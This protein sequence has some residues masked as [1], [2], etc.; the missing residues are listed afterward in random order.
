MASFR[1]A[2][3][4]QKWHGNLWKNLDLCAHVVMYIYC[5]H[6]RYPGTSRYRFCFLCYYTYYSD[7]GQI[8]TTIR[9]FFLLSYV[10]VF[11]PQYL[12]SSPTS[13]VDIS[14]VFSSTTCVR[15]NFGGIVLV[16]TITW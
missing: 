10:D 12:T 9:F 4:P 15:K 16:L 3:Y 11:F 8:I 1:L 6:T 2:I 14:L 7:T 5:T 13:S